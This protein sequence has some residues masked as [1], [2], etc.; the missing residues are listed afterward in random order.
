MKG[1]LW[2]C[3]HMKPNPGAKRS[4][5]AEAQNHKRWEGIVERMLSTRDH[6]HH[7]FNNKGSKL[8][9]RIYKI[10]SWVHRSQKPNLKLSMNWTISVFWILCLLAS[11]SI[12]IRDASY[13]IYCFSS[14]NY[15]KILSFPQIWWKDHQPQN[16]LRSTQMT[17]SQAH[18]RPTGWIWVLAVLIHN[19][20]DCY[21]Q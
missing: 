18:S 5:S 7:P 1:C 13:N 17:D 16:H 12:K 9:D 4:Q 2:L 6:H 14:Y 8:K 20:E 3:A 15:F 21:K 10:C 19:S 11:R